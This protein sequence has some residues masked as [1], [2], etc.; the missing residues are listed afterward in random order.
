VGDVRGKGVGAVEQA[1]RVIRAFRQSAAAGANLATMAQQMS[2][3]LTPFLDDE[4]FVTAALIQITDGT[5][6]T[7]VNCGHPAPLFIPRGGEIR[8][9]DPPIGLPLG[10]GGSYESLSMAW[11]SGDRI[12]LYTDG[13]SEARDQRGEFLP[14][15]PLAPLLRGHLVEDSLDDVLTRVRRHVSAGRLADDLAVLLLENAVPG[16][17]A[18]DPRDSLST[19]PEPSARVAAP[20]D[21][22]VAGRHAAAGRRAGSG[23]AGTGGSLRWGGRAQRTTANRSVTPRP[24]ARPLASKPSTGRQAGRSVSLTSKAAW[25]SSSASACSA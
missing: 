21:P 7:L 18:S 3:Y 23:V 9:L 17:V 11:T 16:E 14:L 24:A 6:V 13:L 1:A 25:D 20:V 2:D 4:E 12:L 5:R 8:F 22:P 15:L 19:S 10:L